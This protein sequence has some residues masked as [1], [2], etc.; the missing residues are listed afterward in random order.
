M[1]GPYLMCSFVLFADENTPLNLHVNGHAE[2]LRKSPNSR[3]D[4]PMSDDNNDIDDDNPSDDDKSAGMG[5][6]V[7]KHILIYS[8]KLFFF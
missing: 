5:L 4:D 7:I 2:D 8:P 1:Y 6:S 3:S